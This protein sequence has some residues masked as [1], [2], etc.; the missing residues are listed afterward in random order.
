M[1]Y[2]PGK[3]RKRVRAR[4]ERAQT[5]SYGYQCVGEDKT[6]NGSFLWAL[7]A[8]FKGFFFFATGVCNYTYFAVLDNHRGESTSHFALVL[9]QYCS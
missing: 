3:P 2:R 1:W 7:W 9:L 5:L 4:A 6:W 8:V